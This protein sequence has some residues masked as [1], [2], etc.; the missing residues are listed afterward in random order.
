ML[1]LYEFG[2]SKRFPSEA[3]VK[4]A[5]EVVQGHLRTQAGKEALQSVRPLG[6]QAKSI[7]KFLMHTLYNLPTRSVKVAQ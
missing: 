5:A 7:Q 1:M 6:G 3:L 4:A 2:K